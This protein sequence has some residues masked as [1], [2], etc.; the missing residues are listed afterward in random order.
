MAAIVVAL[1]AVVVVSMGHQ[2]LSHLPLNAQQQ[3]VADTC[4]LGGRLAAAV[5]RGKRLVVGD[6]S[7][8]P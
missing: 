7:T 6:F 1:L 4:C 2:A 3:A 8:L 5:G